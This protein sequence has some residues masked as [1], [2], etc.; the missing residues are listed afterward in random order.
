MLYGRDTIFLIYVKS[1]L[2]SK[3]LIT[4]LS[5]KGMDNQVNRLFLK[6]YSSKDRPSERSSWKSRAKAKGSL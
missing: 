3:E 1:T 5:G 6:G 2:N 4:K